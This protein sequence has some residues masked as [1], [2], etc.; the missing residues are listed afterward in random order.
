MAEPFNREPTTISIALT[1]D[2]VP[3][4]PIFEN[5]EPVDPAVG[6]VRALL[7]DADI[8]LA[9]LLSPLS[10]NGIPV[11]KM[12]QLRSSPS[13]AADLRA[14]GFDVL[15]LA[16]NHAMDYGPDALADTQAVL[17]AHGIRTLG[18]GPDLAAATE[19]LVTEHDG[20]RVGLLAWSSLLP[21]GAQAGA[22]RP[23]IAPLEVRVSYEIDP[24]YL[25]E[26]PTWPPTVRSSVVEASLDLALERVRAM[27]AEVDVLVVVAHWGEGVG[28]RVGEYQQPLTHALL[29]AGADAVLGTHPHSVHGVEVHDGKPVLYSPG[30]FIDQTPRVGNAPEVDELY[31]HLSPDS[32]VAVLVADHTGVRSVR[33]V[34]TTL[35]SANLPVVA[36]GAAHERIVERLRT[37]SKPYGTQFTVEGRDVVVGLAG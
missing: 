7:G 27:R 29:D 3:S 10:D 24:L 18:A 6:E 14:L 34:P 4:R 19:G 1:G 21:T 22:D 33:I 20:L 2:L 17:E 12:I 36:T 25:T 31:S 13:L 16:N 11:A 37:M 5:G 23:G 26:E 9:S 8:A 30:L 28:D 32:Y 15:H 35:G